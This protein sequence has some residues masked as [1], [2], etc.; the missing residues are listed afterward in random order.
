MKSELIKSVVF[1][2][3]SL[4]FTSCE[5]DDQNDILNDDVNVTELKNDLTS[6]RWEI[7][8]YFD[9]EDETS[10]YNG[11]SFTFDANGVISATNGTDSYTGTWSISDSDSDDDSSNGS[12]EFNIFFANPEIFEEL[13]DDWDFVQHT[14]TMLALRDISGGDG[15]TDLLTFEKM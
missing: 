1:I 12:V 10:D 4:V 7:T 6:G 15:G 14:E 13:S 11:Y 9:D 3:C 8:Y 5:E 2:F